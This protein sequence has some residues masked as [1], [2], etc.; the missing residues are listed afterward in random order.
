VDIGSAV[1]TVG[2]SWS[3]LH[4]LRNAILHGETVTLGSLGRFSGPPLRPGNGLDA[5]RR[6]GSSE[7]S[8]YDSGT[9]PSDS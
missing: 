2:G 7:I 4:G 9:A 5:L 1:Q 6:P 3:F 8:G